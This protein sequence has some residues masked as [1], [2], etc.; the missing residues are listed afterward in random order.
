MKKILKSG[1][2][3]EVVAETAIL[4]ALIILPMAF[5]GPGWRMPRHKP[6]A[7]VHHPQGG[8]SEGASDRAAC[9]DRDES[10][11]SFNGK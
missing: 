10:E 9:L 3:K 7:D 11:S 4:S 5:L 2:M 6:F 1:F 8:G